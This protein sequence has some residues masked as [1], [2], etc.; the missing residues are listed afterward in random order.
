MSSDCLSDDR[1]LNESVDVSFEFI[2]L[3]WVR[4]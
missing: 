3:E 4:I 2:L 1:S